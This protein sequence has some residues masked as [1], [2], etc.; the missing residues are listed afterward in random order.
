MALLR[1]GK[2]A[3]FMA[4]QFTVEQ[5]FVQRR[6]VEGD[7]RPLPALRE[8]MQTVGNQLFTGATLADDQHWL[9]QRCQA[10]NLFHDLQEAIS[11]SDEA[12]LIFRHG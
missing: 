6:A 11:L 7:K 5:V 4:K 9:I 3:G 12:I 10:G 2:R 1:A 8:E